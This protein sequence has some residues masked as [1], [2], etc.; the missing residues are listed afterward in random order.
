LGILAK[1][2]IKVATLITIAIPV[3]GYQ[4]NTTVGQHINVYNKDDGIHKKGG[5]IMGGPAGRTFKGAINVK[6]VQKDDPGWIDSHS[7]MHSNISV[8]KKYIEPILKK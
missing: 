5:P 2:N 6:V 7:T 8:W 1:E 4:L 3:R